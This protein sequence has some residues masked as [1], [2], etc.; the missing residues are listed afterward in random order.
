VTLPTRP[1]PAVQFVK[2]NR[3]GEHQQSGRNEVL[4]PPGGAREPGTGD[5]SG[6]LYADIVAALRYLTKVINQRLE[7]GAFRGE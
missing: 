5:D 3:P 6:A 2:I 4:P 1:H 7:F